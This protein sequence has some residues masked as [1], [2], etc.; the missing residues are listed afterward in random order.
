MAV[1]VGCGSRAVDCFL[2]WLSSGGGGGGM[3]DLMREEWRREVVI[4]S[5]TSVC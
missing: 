5:I 3:R 4:T 2:C 1:G